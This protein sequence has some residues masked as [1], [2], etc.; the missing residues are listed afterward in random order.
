MK[1]NWFSPLPP[2]PTDI[3]SYTMRLLPALQE[4]AEIILW[5]NQSTWC[6]EIEDYAKVRNYKL[7]QMP[8]AEINQGDLNIYQIGNNP[9]FHADIWQIS[10]QCPGLVILHDSKL[11]DFFTILYKEKWG[12]RQGYL[13]QMQLYYGSRGKEAAEAFWLGAVSTDFMAEHYPLTH[14]ALENAV[15]VITHNQ[16]DYNSLGQEKRW[17]V[18][19]LPLP[20][21][22]KFNNLPKIQLNASPPY[23]LII[24]GYINA[25]R[26]LEIVLEALSTFKIKNAFTL[27]IYGQIWNKNLV[28]EK[29]KTL[30]LSDQVKIHGFVKELVL[31]KAL[32]NAD[33]AI[34]LRYPTMGEASGSQLRIWSHALPSLVT[35]IGWY[36]SLPKDTVAFVSHDHELEDIQQQLQNFLDNPKEFA[37]MGKQGKKL[38]EKQHTP[39]IYAQAIIDFSEK[40]CQSRSQS[41][42]YQLAKKVGKQIN[43]WVDYPLSEQ[44]VKRTAEAIHFLTGR[45]SPT[46][47]RQGQQIT[48]TPLLKDRKRDSAESRSFKLPWSLLSFIYKPRSFWTKLVSREYKPHKGKFLRESKSESSQVK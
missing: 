25:K 31:E 43:N 27:D 2:A 28:K 35:K 44:E 22:S 6:S 29:I 8:W 23:K 11:Q 47:D 10:R 12:D 4:R 48:N 18:G 20:Y 34:N 37:T 17:L 24:F 14:L 16:E 32:A 30:G 46:D 5:T 36:A 38:L 40:V 39:E 33:L 45:T 9:D 41:V 13:E 15:G 42:A 1:I 3:A 21:K 7:E 19:Y 26:R